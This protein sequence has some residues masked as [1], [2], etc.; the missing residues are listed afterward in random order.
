MRFCQQRIYT[1][2]RSGAVGR[3]SGRVGPFEAQQIV[4]RSRDRPSPGL[5]ARPSRKRESVSS[6]RYILIC[7]SPFSSLARSRWDWNKTGYEA[8]PFNDHKLN[9]LVLTRLISPSH[10]SKSAGTIH[11]AG[12][13][14]RSRKHHDNIDQINVFGPQKGW[15]KNWWTRKPAKVIIV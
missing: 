13:P 3:A 5:R 8:N 10:G 1:S 4:T 7:R 15:R 11:A 6:R 14:G 9:T 12:L 2:P